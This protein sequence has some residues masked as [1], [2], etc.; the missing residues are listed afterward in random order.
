MVV[1]VAVVLGIGALGIALGAGA[2]LSRWRDEEPDP[3]APERD[4]DDDPPPPPPPVVTDDTPPPVGPDAEADMRR[5]YRA[6][7][8]VQIESL[9]PSGRLLPLTTPSAPTSPRTIDTPWVVPGAELRP[10]L[11]PQPAAGGPSIRHEEHENASQPLAVLARTPSRALVRAADG[12][13]GT[14]IAG[15]LAAFEGY[16]GHFYLPATVPTE[17]GVVQ[18]GGSDGA[19]VYFAI[20]S[21]VMANGGTVRPGETFDV[22]MRLASV[23]RQG[24]ASAPVSRPLR[25]LAV[26]AGDVE[27]TLTMSEPTD[28]DLYVTDP[29]GVVIYF[30]NSRAFSGGQLDL[31]ANAACSSN[32]GVDNEHVFWPTNGAPSGRYEVHVAHY[33]SCIQNRPVNYR[34]TVTACGETAVLSGSFTGS[35]RAESCQN[36]PRPEDRAWCQKV[37]AFDMPG[38]RS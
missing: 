36:A 20:Q 4:P 32:M 24:R 25:V 27:V 6:G 1:S 9:V 2:R 31:D 29:T 8:F 15:Y 23:D 33:E 22:T 19:T 5:R 7:P 18:A 14:D 35:G 37:V 34:V 17:L 3:P 28:L 12:S 30:G 10:G 21:P 26:G 11:L 38:C 13:G 16:P